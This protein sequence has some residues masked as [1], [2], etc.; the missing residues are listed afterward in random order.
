MRTRLASILIL[1]A[2]LASAVSL[3][4]Q[5]GAR[6]N[7]IVEENLHEGSTDWQLTRVRADRDGFRSPW[8]EGYCS[9]QSVA[10]GEPIPRWLLPVGAWSRAAASAC[11]S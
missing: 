5:T 11:A 2:V 10:P 4:D 6:R 8:I 1:A 9:K 7:P 3:A